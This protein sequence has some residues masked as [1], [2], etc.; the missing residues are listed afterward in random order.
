[1]F[2]N[3]AGVAITSVLE[4]VRKYLGRPFVVSNVRLAARRCEVCVG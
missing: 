2:A 1:M 3:M 4:K